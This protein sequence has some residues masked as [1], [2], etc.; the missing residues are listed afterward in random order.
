MPPLPWWVSSGASAMWSTAGSRGQDLGRH[1]G[2]DGLCGGGGVPDHVLFTGGSPGKIS[3]IVALVAAP[4]SGFTELFSW[5]G[6]DTLTVPLVTAC[7][8]LPLVYLFSC[9]GW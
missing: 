2:H 6:A 7:V 1:L 9:L 3:L 5:R 4:L 8:I